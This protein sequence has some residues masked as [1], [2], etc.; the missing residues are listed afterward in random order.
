MSN[1]PNTD[2]QDRFYRV[3]ADIGEIILDFLTGQ[4][5]LHLASRVRLALSGRWLPD[6]GTVNVPIL[7]AL[8][9]KSEITVETMAARVNATVYRPGNENM[10]RCADFAKAQK[11]S[12]RKRG[13]K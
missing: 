6:S 9:D 2:N 12:G 5:F 4:F 7:A 10:F 11:T 13:A 8:L 3:Y 1:Q